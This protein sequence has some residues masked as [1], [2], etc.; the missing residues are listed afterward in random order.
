MSDQA[1]ACPACGRP[2]GNLSP[3]Q[4]TSK[5]LKAQ[6]LIAAAICLCGLAIYL[7]SVCSESPRPIL[8]ATIF[9]AGFGWL[10]TLHFF[11]WWHHR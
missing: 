1:A 8:S 10:C 9:S 4:E 3:A 5:R 11:I 6:Q 2:N 7:I